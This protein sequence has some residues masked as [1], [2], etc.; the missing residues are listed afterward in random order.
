M[1]SILL[2][3][4]VWSDPVYNGIYHVNSAGELVGYNNGQGFNKFSSPRKM[5]SKSGR[6]FKKLGEYP[7]DDLAS[8]AKIVIGSKGQQ[9]V[10]DNGMCSCPGF[11]FRGACKH[12]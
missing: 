6:T 4:T 10:V 11:K 5:F 8:T 2:E 9:Y 12:V 7:E 3:T 1:I